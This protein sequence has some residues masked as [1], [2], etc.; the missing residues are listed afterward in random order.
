MELNPVG[1]CLNSS[2]LY[3][4]LYGYNAYYASIIHNSANV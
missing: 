2:K 1:N 3:I 4:V